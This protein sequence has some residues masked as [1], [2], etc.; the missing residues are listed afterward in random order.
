MISPISITAG[1]RKRVLHVGC[2]SNRP[3]KLHPSFNADGWQEIRLD[4]DAEVQPDIVACITD[5]RQVAEASVEAIWSSHNLEH[6]Y[7]HE[8]PLALKEFWRV[9]KPDGFVL[10]TLPDLQAAAEYVARGQLEEVIYVSPA[11]PVSA[12]DMCYGFRPALATGN[13]FMAHKTGFT[14][15]TL[16]Q[17][18]VDRGFVDVRVER[19]NLALWAIGHRPRAANQND[20]RDL[21][22][23][24]DGFSIKR[25]SIGGED[26]Q[27]SHRE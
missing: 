22:S 14:A 18:L 24:A 5:M 19:E 20:A 9:L 3:G 2:G 10:I 4:I 11:G 21:P 25:A 6:L 1:A 15:A 7:A 16:R 13:R 17:K 23:V 26:A 8:V 12:L 27:Q